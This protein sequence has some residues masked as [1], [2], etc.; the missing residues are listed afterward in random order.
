MIIEIY[1]ELN[2]IDI[3]IVENATHIER[4]DFTMLYPN[5]KEENGSPMKNKQPK[6]TKTTKLKRRK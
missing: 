3:D 1:N 4:F 6:M 2:G 5:D